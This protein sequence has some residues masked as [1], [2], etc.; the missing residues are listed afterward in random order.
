MASHWEILQGL[1]KKCWR[2]E[3]QLTT[4][5]LSAR[6]T[7]LL[8][9]PILRHYLKVSYS[10][11]V[12]RNSDALPAAVHPASLGS[13]D[14]SSCEARITSMPFLKHEGNK[15]SSCRLQCLLFIPR[16]R[17]LAI[18]SQCSSLL[19]GISWWLEPEHS[20]TKDMVNLTLKQEH[21]SDTQLQL[22]H[23]DTVRHLR[24]GHC[25]FNSTASYW[26]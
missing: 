15:F 25:Y 19:P 9:C 7:V 12:P 23:P 5:R 17:L 22:Q 10:A 2:S 3:P 11:K 14:T 26:L 20:Q 21:H 13:H 16:Q 6:G 1:E 24:V 8:C 18:A 4:G